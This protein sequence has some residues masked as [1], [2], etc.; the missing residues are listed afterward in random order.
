ME[1]KFRALRII[2]TV[3][4]IL[5]W[6]E[7]ALGILAAIGILV[8]GIMGG[9]LYGTGGRD[10]LGAGMMG[11]LLGGLVGGLFVFIIAVLYFLI[12]YATGEFIYLG[13]AVEENTRETAVLLRDAA[14]RLEAS[15]STPG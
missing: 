7:L 8:S 4:K 14:A 6:I 3:F 1:K 12:L 2:G 11:G 10:I 15:T 9:A 5:A 13:L